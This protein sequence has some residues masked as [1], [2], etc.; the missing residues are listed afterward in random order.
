MKL[1]VK[2]LTFLLV[3]GAI[4][5]GC[6]D[7]RDAE[8]GE[9]FSKIEGL[10][11]TKWEI[12]SV[13]IVDGADP[14]RSSRDFSQFYLNGD[15]KLTLTFDED[16]T[17]MVEVGEGLN[18]LPSD[19]TWQFDDPDYPTKIILNAGSNPQE[20]QLE[21]TTRFVDQELKVRFDK[22]FCV[23]EEGEPEVPVYSYRLIFQRLNN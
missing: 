23:L 21:A 6:R 10:T 7:I 18:F 19:G 16:Y 8:L 4:V 12:T 9:P 5:S 1:F 17:F 2:T 20:L 22:Y 13:S 14:A 11:L 3:I 15:T